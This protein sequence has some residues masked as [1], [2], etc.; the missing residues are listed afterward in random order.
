MNVTLVNNRSLNLRV[1]DIEIG[2]V[3]CLGG[4]VG[5]YMR[6]DPNENN[7]DVSSRVI[8]KKDPVYVIALGNSLSR[9]TLGIL[10]GNLPVS[11]VIGTLSID[12]P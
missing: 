11:K 12:L 4:E 9:H 5:P 7:I 6:I 1:K 8:G 10:N 3:F 2:E